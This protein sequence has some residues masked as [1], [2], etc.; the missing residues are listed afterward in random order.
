[1]PLRR[2]KALR[3]GGI[4]RLRVCAVFNERVRV[5]KILTKKIGIITPAKPENRD[6]KFRAR[7][8]K[9]HQEEKL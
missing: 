1:M 4:K 7:S 3:G 5:R 9:I 2:L 8:L 6:R